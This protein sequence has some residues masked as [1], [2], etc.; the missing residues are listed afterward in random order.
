MLQVQPWKEE[1]LNKIKDL[2]ETRQVSKITLFSV[3]KKTI[4]TIIE[5]ALFLFIYLTASTACA[6]SGAM[7]RTQVTAITRATVVKMLD[8]AELQ[9]TTASIIFKVD[10]TETLIF[11][12]Y[13]LFL[14]KLLQQRSTHILPRFLLLNEFQLLLQ[15]LLNFRNSQNF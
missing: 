14:L 10:K 1:K 13:C 5:L 12:H 6:S 2:K 11:R 4:K 8:P 3:K 9:E 7:D 15:E